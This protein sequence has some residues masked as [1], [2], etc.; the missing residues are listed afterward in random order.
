MIWNN[1]DLADIL[2]V[3]EIKDLIWVMRFQ[4]PLVYVIAAKFR[5]VTQQVHVIRGGMPFQILNLY[6]GYKGCERPVNKAFVAY[7]MI[8]WAKMHA[9]LIC[10]TALAIKTL[11]R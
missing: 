8:F 10:T 9:S 5:W 4:S 1:N 2:R 3:C 11:D 7:G 6:S